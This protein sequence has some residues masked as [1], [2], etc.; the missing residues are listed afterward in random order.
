MTPRIFVSHSSDDRLIGDELTAL[1]V[2]S[3]IGLSKEDLLY[4]G[5]P[6]TGLRAGEIITPSLAGEIAKC[7][8]FV[9]V[10]SE[11]WRQSHY[12]ASE[13][14]A[15][16][17]SGKQTIV[18][19]LPEIIPEQAGEPLSGMHMLPLAEPESV[20]AL[21]REVARATDKRCEP[22]SHKIENFCRLVAAH[23]RNPVQEW[24][25][26]LVRVEE[27]HVFLNGYGLLQKPVQRSIFQ[28]FHAAG[29]NVQP[30]QFMWA[31][32]RKGNWINPKVVMASRPQDSLLRIEFGNC[33][34]SLGCNVSIRPQNRE[35][36]LLGEAV[37]MHIDARV[38]DESKTAEVGILVRLVNGYMQHWRLSAGQILRV[39]RGHFQD[40][41][42]KLD[43]RCWAIF[44]SDGTGGAG[45]TDGPDFSI[46]SSVNLE[47]GGWG[48]FAASP[49]PGDGIVELREI[50]FE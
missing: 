3:I 29:P 44:D 27:G 9:A 15:A 49:T 11:S 21:L 35:A 30:V 26:R 22:D 50:R 2:W 46:I 20:E 5:H 19:Y 25:K 13:F 36:L 14:G 38:P 17:A 37:T 6:G 1:L 8:C 42:E 16:L 34:G 48:E 40:V 31:D 43:P 23:P 18:G 41:F 45:P 4:T 39:Q 12:C 24:R 47:L 10:V 32:P 33:V 28:N 7:F